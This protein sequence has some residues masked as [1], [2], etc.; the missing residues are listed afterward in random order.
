MVEEIE[1][2]AKRKMDHTQELLKKDLD[3]VRTGRANAEILN[4]I[5]IDYYGTPTPLNQMASLNTPDPQLI[6]ITP[7]DKSIS[8][9]IEKA[10]LT[11]DLGLNPSSD[12]TVIRVPIPLLTEE[13]RKELVKHVKK[14]GEEGKIALRN[15][16][17]D[18]NERLKKLEKNK[19]ISQD[20]EKNAHDNIQNVTDTHTQTVDE[21]VKEKEKA[22]LTV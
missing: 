10:I 8:K 11:S 4:P 7:F 2:E 22:L 6:T 14:M 15:I 1:A 19:E 21:L 16:R 20:A 13:R 3:A 12:G 18:A 9:D 5:V 17:R